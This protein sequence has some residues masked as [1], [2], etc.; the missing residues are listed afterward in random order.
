MPS[1]RGLRDPRQKKIDSAARF[2]RGSNLARIIH[3]PFARVKEHPVAEPTKGRGGRSQESRGGQSG[4][5][6]AVPRLIPEPYQPPHGQPARGRGN[7]N[8]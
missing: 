7:R 8:F 2:P 4:V 5:I 3:R 1:L 6:D